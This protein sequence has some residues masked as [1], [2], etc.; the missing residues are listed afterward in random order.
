MI[1]EVIWLKNFQLN[2]IRHLDNILEF[3]ENQ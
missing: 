1:Y 3:E 2:N